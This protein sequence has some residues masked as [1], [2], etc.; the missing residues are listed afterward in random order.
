MI[1]NIS[2]KIHKQIYNHY[3]INHIEHMILDVFNIV[4]EYFNISINIYISNEINII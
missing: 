2:L 3:T 4:D 1:L